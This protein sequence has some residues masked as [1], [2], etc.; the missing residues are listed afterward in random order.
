MAGRRFALERFGLRGIMLVL[1][2]I[3]MVLCA[4]RFPS[5]AHAEEMVWKPLTNEYVSDI[6]SYE[7]QIIADDGILYVSYREPIGTNI[8]KPMVKKYD[9]GQWNTVGGGPVSPGAITSMHMAL[10]PSDK[11]L[12]VAYR[13]EANSSKASVVKLTNN[14]WVPLGQYGV[15]PKGV[16]ALSMT[17]QNGTPYMVFG[18]YNKSNKL[19]V[20]KFMNNSWSSVGQDGFTDK[21]PSGSSKSIIKVV[22][23]IVYVAYKRDLGSS[24][25]DVA[26]MKYDED[27]P[28]DGW[29]PVGGTL[30]SIADANSRFFAF[31]VYGGIPYVAYQDHNKADKLTV[32][33]YEGSWKTVGSGP[34]SAGK[35]GYASLSFD[36]GSLYIAYQD[37]ANGKKLMVK[38]FNGSEW[39]M[40]GDAAITRGEVYYPS[41]ALDN[42]TLYVGY[43]DDDT[44]LTTPIANARA[45]VITYGTPLS[46]SLSDIQV[47]YGTA[48]ADALPST[49]PMKWT[50]DT[51]TQVAVTWDQGNPSYNGKTPGTYIFKGQLTIPSGKQNTGV[52][53][54]TVKVTVADPSQDAALIGLTTSEGAPQPAFATGTKSYSRSVGNTVSQISVTASL[55]DPKGTMTIGGTVATNGVPSA[56]IFLRVGPNVIDVTVTAEDGV[57]TDHYTITV[58]R[59]GSNN[60][61]LSNLTT[62]AGTLTP[63]FASGTTLYNQSV[64]NSVYSVSVTASVYELNATLKIGGVP[65]PSGVPS[66]AIPLQVG[67]NTIAVEVTAQDGVSKGH[68]TITVTR[69][70][71]NNAKLSDLTTNAGALTP[72]FADGTTAYSQTVANSIYSLSVTASVYEPNATLKIGGVPMP[73]GV[74]SAAI[75]L[76]VGNNTIVVEVTAQDG[77]TTGRYTIIVT[78]NPK[79]NDARIGTLSL[80]G[81]TLDQT[82]SGSVYAYTATVPY[83]VSVTSATYSTAESHATSTLQLNGAPVSNPISLSVGSNV[84]SIIVTAQD[85]TTQTYSVNVTR[86]GSHSSGGSNAI[87]PVTPTAPEPSTIPTT[88]ETSGVPT[89]AH[90]FTVNVNSLQLISVLKDRIAQAKSSSAAVSLSDISNHWSKENINLF[91]N[92]GVISGY[93]D[94]TFHPDSSVTRAEFATLISKV[95]NVQPTSKT[96]VVSDV[97]N[98]WAKESIN[99]LASH[100]IINGYEDGT[101]KPDKKITRAE[102]IAIISRIVDFNVVKK[103]YGTLAFTDIDGSWNA[104]QIQVASDAGLVQGRDA[105]TF[106]PDA[107]STKAESLTI[108]LRV[109]NLNPDIKVLLDQI[110]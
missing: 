101:F 42:G 61:K 47:P 28:S 55:R 104:A 11:T 110:K 65:S 74:P 108:I 24:N 59:E 52:R 20:M 99:V 93:E 72:L 25:V 91:V 7:N 89:T 13:D 84:I 79:S 64:S 19:T 98:H 92:L 85:G 18:D 102:I 51:T 12:Y 60:A 37:G 57:T 38:Q 1:I 82:V 70:G 54:V 17:V 41:I 95:F 109:L 48:I 32:L 53:E 15:T 56:P 39:T 40:V 71:S 4:L 22:D 68:Y 76:Q 67:N 46:V 58:M 5:S 78:R 33:K 26:I 43:Q 73:S 44:L 16:Y 3:L 90:I 35:V 50:D 80:S 14:Q 107:S 62:S 103:D 36:N 88:P 69:E 100:G 86:V 49:V 31:D 45:F 23:R 9:G 27:H 6:D 63:L 66:A 34:V 87:T 83:S 97:S 77:T 30:P 81:I 2:L 75:P 94:G 105:N 10:D 96:S 106:A 8:Y 21:A 29:Q